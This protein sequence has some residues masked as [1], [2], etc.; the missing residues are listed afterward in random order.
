MKITIPKKVEFE[1]SYLA[2]SVPVR[3]DDG[4]PANLPGF[5]GELW[6]ATINVDTG[7]INGWSYPTP[8]KISLHV[9]DEGTYKLLAPDGAV[10]ASLVEAYVPNLII[11][12]DFGDWVELDVA[13]DGKITNWPKYPRLIEF[14][15]DDNE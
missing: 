12:G 14:V 9:C 3:D 15:G 13:P 11:P 5:T 10:I 4:L 8:F 1:V 7:T 2:L 6:E